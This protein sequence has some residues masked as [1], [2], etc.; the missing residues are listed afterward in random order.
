MMFNLRDYEMLKQ[1][2]LRDRNQ[3][4]DGSGES[5]T[6]NFTVDLNL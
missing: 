3:N 5:G 2:T 6:V 1:V 4:T